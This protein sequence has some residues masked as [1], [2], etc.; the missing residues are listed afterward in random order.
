[1]LPYPIL[2]ELGELFVV[3][4][5]VIFFFINHFFTFVGFECLINCKQIINEIVSNW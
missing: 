4:Q 1:M 2:C 5:A 3:F